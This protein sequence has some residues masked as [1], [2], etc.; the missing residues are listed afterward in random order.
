MDLT[1]GLIALY[2]FFHIYAFSIN[3]KFLD[4]MY[5]QQNETV[6]LNQLA[7]F[8]IFGVIL[9]PIMTLMIISDHNNRLEK[10]EKNE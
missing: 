3:M 6:T 10:G 5:K 4:I 1:N 2:I 7:I 9:A 8:W